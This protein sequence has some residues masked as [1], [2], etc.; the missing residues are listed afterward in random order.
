M[1]RKVRV[2]TLRGNKNAQKRCTYVLAIR[3]GLAIDGQVPGQSTIEELLVL[4]ASVDIKPIVLLRL[5]IRGD[6]RDC[7]VVLSPENKH[8]GN[9]R[10]ARLSEDAH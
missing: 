6:L 7:L 5:P 10:V 9:V 8:T 2:S 4:L 3:P 1:S